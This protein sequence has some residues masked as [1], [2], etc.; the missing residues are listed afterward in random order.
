MKPPERTKVICVGPISE[1]VKRE[2]GNR[3][4][5]ISA[6]NPNRL[7]ISLLR[8]ARA[9]LVQFDRTKRE[10]IAGLLAKNSVDALNAGA[11]LAVV[12][13]A[14]ATQKEDRTSVSE[15]AGSLGIQVKA[16]NGWAAHEVAEECA[17][18]HA[19]RPANEK[20]DIQK[21]EGLVLTPALETLL[22]RAFSD[23]NKIRVSSLQGG[24]SKRISGVWRIEAYD[25]KGHSLE[26][27]VVK[28][29]EKVLI[30][31][32]R[33][34][35]Q[36]LVLDRIP[37]PNRPPLVL[38]RCVEGATEA[39]LTSK[40]IDRAIRF[41]HYLRFGAPMLAISSLF[42]GPMRTW[43]HPQ[44]V[45]AGEVVGLAQEYEK[46]QVIPSP[47]TT[48]G[49]VK[50][51]ELAR[52]KY[53]ANVMAPDTLLSL[54]F[55]LDRVRV[56]LCYC[57]GDL[58]T[59]NMFV[60]HNSFDVLLIDFRN[61]ASL[62]PTARDPAKLDVGIAFDVWDDDRTSR[63]LPIDELRVLYEP[64]LLPVRQAVEPLST[65]GE[66]IRHLRLLASVDASPLE[67]DL[68]VCFN[69]L[70]FARFEPE[71]KSENRAAIKEAQSTAYYLGERIASYV[72]KNAST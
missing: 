6:C 15:I 45:M 28:A 8:D 60:R 47:Q 55:D 12:L 29:G 20:L 64:P 24:K 68:T 54:L 13:P 46:H 44:N 66:A 39:L 25:E 62:S 51:Y 16:L 18:H 31:E 42:D 49:L 38:E 19:G 11:L 7:D 48:H 50:S 26:P 10:A 58:H 56:S 32:E 33:Q 36:D 4:L 17:R 35:M 1:D 65:R 34:G 72:V 67:Y 53:S 63:P 41:D 40:F 14:A 21:E 9:A 22:S 57:H 23:I 27:Y 70:N 71:E 43:R 2:L 69:L 30:K 3:R 61:A 37:F 5:S 59:R 52:V